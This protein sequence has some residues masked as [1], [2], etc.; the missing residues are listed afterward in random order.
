MAATETAPD[1]ITAE[2]LETLVREGWFDDPISS[3]PGWQR[4]VTA[5]DDQGERRGLQRVWPSSVGWYANFGSGRWTE[6]SSWSDNLDDILRW[7]NMLPEGNKIVS[8]GG[9]ATRQADRFVKL[10]EVPGVHPA[11]CSV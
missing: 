3:L 1:G 8:S 7:S 5:E 9:V 4:W 6:I 11:D 10:R 2:H